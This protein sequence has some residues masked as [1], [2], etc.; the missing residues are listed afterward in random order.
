MIA[1]AEVVAVSRT[2]VAR[3]AE[4]KSM[5]TPWRRPYVEPPY[6]SGTPE[7]PPEPPVFPASLRLTFPPTAANGPAFAQLFH[8]TVL[9]VDGVD[10]DYSVASLD[11]VDGFLQHHHDEGRT[12]ADFAETVFAAGCYV[13]EV[14][15]RHAGGRWVDRDSAGI[16]GATGVFGMP[17]LV[18]LPG[19]STANPLAKAYKRFSGAPEDNLPYFYRVFTARTAPGTN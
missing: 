17:I 10:L 18:A 15:C 14:M 5:V 7:P 11:W 13:G 16:P 3:T 12:V 1:N 4:G 19:D 2:V 8:D 9:D 6:G